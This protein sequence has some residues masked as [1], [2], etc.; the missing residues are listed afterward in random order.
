MSESCSNAMCWWRCI[1]SAV[2]IG[3]SISSLPLF[4]RPIIFLNSRLQPTT[5]DLIYTMDLLG[6][7]VPTLE[8][9]CHVGGSQCPGPYDLCPEGDTFAF[10]PALLIYDP[11]F[12]I[13]LPYLLIF[14]L[15]HCFY[16]FWK[17]QR[18]SNDYIPL[19]YQCNIQPVPDN[20]HSQFWVSYETR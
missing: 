15:S 14:T 10:L 1:S 12:T 5:A 20:V 2:S 3:D 19:I 7:K 13:S 11:H 9:E 16:S 4:Y 17:V 18:R 6:Q 8:W